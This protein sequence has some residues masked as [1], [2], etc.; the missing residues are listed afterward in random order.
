MRQSLGKKMTDSKTSEEC[1]VPGCY[2]RY[3][4]SYLSDPSL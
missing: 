3:V 2:G 4:N 1:F